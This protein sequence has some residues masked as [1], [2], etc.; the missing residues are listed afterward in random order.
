MIKESSENQIY[1]YKSD[2]KVFKSNTIHINFII[3]NPEL[4]NINLDSIETTYKAYNEPFGTEGKSREAILKKVMRNGWVRV[5]YNPTRNR[6]WFIEVDL[7]SNRKNS[8]QRCIEYFYLMKSTM[9][10]SDVIE[11]WDQN[12]LQFSGITYHVF[13]VL[14]KINSKSKL[15]KNAI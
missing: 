6:T 12:G 9:K 13:P 4:F 3:D 8:I 15:F 2:S 11:I 7:F 1:W 5:R 14:E 10:S